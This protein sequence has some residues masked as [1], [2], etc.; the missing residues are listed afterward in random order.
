[1]LK[2]AHKPKKEKSVKVYG[3]NLRVSEKHSKIV[4]R[5]ITN[6]RVANARKLLQNLINEKASIKGK[7]YTKT[8]ME[9]LSLLTSAE[10]NAEFKGMDAER[11]VVHA[12][13]HRGF[14]YHTPR[15]FKLAR[16]AAR[17]TN[18]QLVLEEK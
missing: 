4:C 10:N 1:M 8:S 5:A 14:T 13:A 17:I 9:I 12:S 18:L 3:R 2:Y 6:T 16:R 7:Y 15:R 11:M